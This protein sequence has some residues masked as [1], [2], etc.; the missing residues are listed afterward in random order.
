MSEK[1]NHSTNSVDQKEKD[2]ALLVASSTNPY[3]PLCKECGICAC[4][5][6]LKGRFEISCYRCGNCPE[7]NIPL[8]DASVQEIIPDFCKQC[9]TFSERYLND[10]FGKERP[11]WKRTPLCEP[12]SLL[13]DWKVRDESV[14]RSCKNGD[15]MAEIETRGPVV[16]PGIPPP[17]VSST[18][19]RP[20]SAVLRSR[21]R[22]KLREKKSK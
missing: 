2:F 11:G 19:A 20:S 7:C 4:C 8:V 1:P 17:V 9:S 3:N 10:I 5:D 16:R 13:E 22:A 18:E 12:C 21:L 6:L 15:Q 14:C